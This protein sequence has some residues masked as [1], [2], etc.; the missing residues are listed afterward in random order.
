MTLDILM[1]QLG[2]SVTEGTIV[3]WLKKP[4]DPVSIYET[5]CEVETDK[6]NAEVPATEEGTLLEILVNEGETVAVG[7]LIARMRPAGKEALSQPEPPSDAKPEQKSE[8]STTKRK[9]SMKR[10]YSPAVLRLA[11]EHD[12][13]LTLIT[14]TGKNG[15]ITRKDVLRYIQE[16]KG[17]AEKKL[18]IS[19]QKETTPKSLEKVK[20]E[21]PSVPAPVSERSNLQQG[22]V[23]IP[24]SGIRR[25]IAKRMVSSTQEIPHAWLMM[26]ANVTGLVGLRNR[27]KQ[28]FFER[29][30]INLTYLPFFMKAAIDG[31]KAFPYLNSVWENDKIILKKRI[32]ISLA[33]AT[34]EAL[35]VPVIPDADEKSILGL[36]REIHRLVRKVREKKLEPADIEGGTFT[37]NNTGSFGSIISKPIINPPQAAI[38][39]FESIVKRP[40]VVDGAIAVQDLMNICLSFDHRVFDGLMAGRFLNFVKQRLEAFDENTP[41]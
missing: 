14:G 31:L 18:V 40:V 15:R 21:P 22:D 7:T 2:E 1:P 16:Q 8:E 3:R 5:I 34:D 13:D 9:S 25:T 20:V 27:L 4:G 39:T 6:V 28:E 26:E 33:V 23:E 24:V 12:L 35:Y 11:Q 41:V 37:V 38:I 10:R 29:E 30:G 36:A 32:N 17:S 19:E